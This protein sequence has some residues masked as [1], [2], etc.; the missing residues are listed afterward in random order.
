MK[1]AVRDISF[2]QKDLRE[3]LLEFKLQIH[4]NS[5]LEGDLEMEL[6]DAYLNKTGD[7]NS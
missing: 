5:L 7:T 6:D 3:S 2:P 1:D 4:K